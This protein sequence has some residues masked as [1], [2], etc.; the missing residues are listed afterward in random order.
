MPVG[1]AGAAHGPYDLE[2]A[3][4]RV[5]PEMGKEATGV[6]ACGV[7][8]CGSVR[9]ELMLELYDFAHQS[10]PY[11]PAVVTREK[12]TGM[13]TGVSWGRTWC[14]VLVL[15][16]QEP[17]I[18]EATEL[19]S[20]KANLIRVHKLLYCSDMVHEPFLPRHSGNA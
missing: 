6:L 9:H 16:I 2:E 15:P 11:H 13:L 19:N 4:H 20:C 8:A 14:T 7:G 1:G 18:S 17:V 3:L 5:F 12:L 10:L